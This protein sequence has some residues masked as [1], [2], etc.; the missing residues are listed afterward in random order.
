LS[1]TL[2]LIDYEK[3]VGFCFGL[4]TIPNLASLASLYSGIYPQPY[5]VDELIQVVLN[6]DIAYYGIRHP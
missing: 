6:L 5:R 4:L 2:I 3:S 1:A